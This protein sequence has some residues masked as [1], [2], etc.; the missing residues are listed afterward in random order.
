VLQAAG[1]SGASSVTGVTATMSLYPV[2]NTSAGT[3]QF[4][5]QPG[6]CVSLHGIV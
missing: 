2:F 3:G 1:T 6:A 5:I 4:G